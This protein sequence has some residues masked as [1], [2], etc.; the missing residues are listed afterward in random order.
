MNLGAPGGCE[1]SLLQTG[2]GV[3]L[4][5]APRRRKGSGCNGVAIQAVLRVGTVVLYDRDRALPAPWLG[6]WRA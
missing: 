1:G 6:E 5:T 4:K 3:V 2:R